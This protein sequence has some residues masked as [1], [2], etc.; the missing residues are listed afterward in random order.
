M[1]RHCALVFV[2]AGLLLAGGGAAPA[3]AE[4]VSPPSLRLVSASVAVSGI[5]YDRTVSVDPGVYV[6][7]VGGDVE[8]ARGAP[9]TTAP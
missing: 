6:A 4:E 8:F 5:L 3:L 9:T 2:T 7:A 1:I